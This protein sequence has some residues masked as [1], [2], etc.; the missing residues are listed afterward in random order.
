M[1]GSGRKKYFH[2]DPEM[3]LLAAGA[4]YFEKEYVRDQIV[5]SVTDPVMEIGS[6]HPE[7]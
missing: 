1:P 6:F 5:Q 7:K 3:E 2:G 4:F